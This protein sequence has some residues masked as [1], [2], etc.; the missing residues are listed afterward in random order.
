[1]PINDGDLREK[2]VIHELDNHFVKDLS[3]NMRHLLK[4][5]FGVIDDQMLVKCEKVDEFCKTDFIIEYDGRKRNVSMKSGK[6]VIVHN[7]VISNFLSFLKEKGI[8]ERTI[9][10]IGL[11]HYGDGTVDGTG[12]DERQSY[13]DV[14]TALAERIKEANTELNS[15]MDFILEIMNRCVFKGAREEF[16]EADCVYFGDK[17]YGEVATKKQFIKNTM[18]RGFD[19]FD[20]LHIGPI[21]LRPHSRYVKKDISYQRNR[22]RIV[23]YWPHLREDIE[24]MSKRFNY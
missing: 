14:S 6:A 24:Y 13:E 20:H 5:L 22:D 7:E 4:A 16:L 12:S 23:C 18:R 11:F 10:T 8:S 2:E 9:E 17:D 3:N 15:N 21:L 1:M 19:Y